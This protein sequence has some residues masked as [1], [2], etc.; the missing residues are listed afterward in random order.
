MDARLKHLRWLWTQSPTSYCRCQVPLKFND[1]GR[2]LTLHVTTRMFEIQNAPPSLKP[3]RERAF[4]ESNDLDRLDNHC[5]TQQFLGTHPRGYPTIHLSKSL[6]EGA[7]KPK[8][9]VAIAVDDFRH[10][11]RFSHFP[12]TVARLGEAN[13]ILRF[14]P[15]NGLF[16]K[17]FR[18]VR[19]WLSSGYYSGSTTRQCQKRTTI[20]RRNPL[21]S[22]LSLLE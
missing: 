20:R 5:C 10:S 4:R 2:S 18:P 11:R 3:S 12:V 22:R 1:Q 17:S 16:A 8:L 21:P 7:K 14:N 6:K 13:T 19:V 9:S 15:V